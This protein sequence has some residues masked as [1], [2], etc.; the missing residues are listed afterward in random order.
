MK[1]NLNKKKARIYKHLVTVSWLFFFSLFL[2][3]SANSFAQS[4]LYPEFEGVWILDSVQVKE[5][6]PESVV[7]KTVLPGGRSNFDGNWMWQ[8]TLNAGG[9]ADYTETGNRT[10]S[11]VHYFIKDKQGNVATLII[12]GVPDYKILSVALLS[13]NTLLY[14]HSFTTGYNLQNIEVSWKMYY[15]KSNN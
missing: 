12:D 7:Q 14:A 10:I 8:F 2:F 4:S 6:L 13:D 15:H 9:K 5:I 3:P 11:D 1:T